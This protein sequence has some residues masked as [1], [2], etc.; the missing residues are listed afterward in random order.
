LTFRRIFENKIV[1]SPSAVTG[2]ATTQHH[3]VIVNAGSWDTLHGGVHCIAETRMR[4]CWGEIESSERTTGATVQSTRVARAASA[5]G[6]LD[7]KVIQGE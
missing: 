3:A 2:H 4:W 6:G 7:A 1:P 5:A